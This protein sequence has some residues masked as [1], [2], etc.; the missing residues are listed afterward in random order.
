M[1]SQPSASSFEGALEGVT[2]APYC[3]T[4]RSTAKP[5]GP[6]EVA[7]QALQ[8]IA[9]AAQVEGVGAHGQAEGRQ[10]AQG[11]LDR[12]SLGLRLGR[13][14]LELVDEAHPG[15]G[16]GRA[17]GEA[18]QLEGAPEQPV[19][20][21]PARAPGPPRPAPPA[22]RCHRA[23]RSPPKTCAPS[24]LPQLGQLRHG[25]GD[26]LVVVQVRAQAR[27]SRRYSRLA[28]FRCTA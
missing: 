25:R 14:P 4:R 11:R 6:G 26:G 16:E 21:L 12:L 8:A 1:T 9:L 7:H 3:K 13:V 28:G 18:G 20:D 5:L 10:D 24:P 17:V 22:R 19:G 27:A 15:L 2:V 23:A